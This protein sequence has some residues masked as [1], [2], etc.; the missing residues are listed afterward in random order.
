MSQNNARLPDLDHVT[1]PWP[2]GIVANIGDLML[3]AT[4]GMA[5]LTAGTVYPASSMPHQASAAADQALAA[6]AFAGVAKERKLS[7]DSGSAT[8]PEGFIDVVPVWVGDMP[9]V[10][11]AW[12]LGDSVTIAENPGVTGLMANQLDKTAV[13]GSGIGRV[14]KDTGGVAVTT[15]RVV[16]RSNVFSKNL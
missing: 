6:P 9:C 8:D 1:C 5:G 16:L 11:Q 10:S 4:S 12:K 2:G 13:A 7:T 15:V 14:V 3:V